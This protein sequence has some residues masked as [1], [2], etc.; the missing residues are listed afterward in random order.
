MRGLRLTE[1]STRGVL[2]RDPVERLMTLDVEPLGLGGLAAR[3]LGELG[4]DDDDSNSNSGSEEL[5]PG[6]TMTRL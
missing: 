5:G 3:G 6:S 4:C 2:E 1:V